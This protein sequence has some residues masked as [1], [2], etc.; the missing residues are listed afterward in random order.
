MSGAARDNDVNQASWSGPGIA[1]AVYD[2]SQIELLQREKAEKERIAQRQEEELT[3][4]MRENSEMKARLERLEALLSAQ[5]PG[6]F[7]TGSQAE[8]LSNTPTSQDQLSK[9]LEKTQDLMTESEN[10]ARNLDRIAKMAAEESQKLDQLQKTDAENQARLEEELR[11]KQDLVKQ[12]ER[13]LEDIKQN[14]SNRSVSN[15]M[16][17][18]HFHT[19]KQ[20]EKHRNRENSKV[21]HAY[22]HNS[23]MESDEDSVAS[24]QNKSSNRRYP[25]SYGQQKFVN[26]TAFASDPQNVAP[27]VPSVGGADKKRESPSRGPK[28]ELFGPEPIIETLM[29]N[30]TQATDPN[31]LPEHMDLISPMKVGT[32]IT[33]ERRGTDPKEP[34]K[35]EQKPIDKQFKKHGEGRGAPGPKKPDTKT[36]QESSTTRPP[37][38]D[39]YKNIRSYE[40]YYKKYKSHIKRGFELLEEEE[41]VLKG[42]VIGSSDKNPENPKKGNRSI[43][44]TQEEM[45]EYKAREAEAESQ[46][47][48]AARTKR[49]DHER[50][51]AETVEV[52]QQGGTRTAGTGD[53]NRREEAKQSHRDSSK[54]ETQ[55]QVKESEKVSVPAGNSAPKRE[56]SALVSTQ[57]TIIEED[58]QECAT[59]TEAQSVAT[60]TTTQKKPTRR[61][62]KAAR[63]KRQ[64]LMEKYGK[65][66]RDPNESSQM[67]QSQMSVSQLGVEEDSTE[68][69]N[70][71][72]PTQSNQANTLQTQTLPV[73][74]SPL[75]PDLDLIEAS[76]Q[77]NSSEEWFQVAGGRDPPPAVTPVVPVDTKSKDTKPKPSVD[78]KANKNPAKP[79]P[80]NE[81]PASEK[82][83]PSTGTAPRDKGEKTESTN[84]RKGPSAE[85]RKDNKGSR[86]PETGENKK[87]KK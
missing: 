48:E 68:G 70:D 34:Q 49:R 56:N 27:T 41:Y 74:R 50:P 86:K 4:L 17:K 80:N 62:G 28:R 82:P 26:T 31:D 36:K 61:G 35:G 47:K 71:P 73:H 52:S 2:L 55:V 44:R 14:R 33:G 83:G 72:L 23:W 53:R 11:Q 20:A 43:F 54:T 57:P 30:Q 9:E 15:S 75:L 24:S 64:K 21:S 66:S 12:K 84:N 16:S 18:T 59:A 78:N 38:S 3:K 32:N 77:E 13:D 46:A 8:T 19:S 87:K 85:E 81:A 42:S 22:S 79:K 5:V 63:L 67:V 10:L 25:T 51:K 37:Y 65:L 7:N 60:I 39:R 58:A 45:R 6:I 29:E 1:A 76:D 69:K 40:D